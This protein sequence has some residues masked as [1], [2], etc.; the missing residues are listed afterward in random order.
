MV[1]RGWRIAP[2]YGAYLYADFNS[3]EMW[4]LRHSGM[5]VT[6]NSIILTNSGALIVA[7]GTDPSNGDALCAAVRSGTN[8]T[9]ERLVGPPAPRITQISRIGTNLVIRGTNGPPT[10]TYYALASTNLTVP[11]TG[12][13]SVSTSLFDSGGNFVFTNPIA[14]AFPRRFYRLLVP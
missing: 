9:I 2:L 8:S 14:P 1:Y 7:F 4:A 11:A 12:W 13:V 6:Q 3:G 10:Q 5:S